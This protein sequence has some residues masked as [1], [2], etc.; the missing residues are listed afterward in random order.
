MCKLKN[1]LPLNTLVTLYNTLILPY[2]GFE[3]TKVDENCKRDKISFSL[4]KGLKFT[5]I[6]SFHPSLKDIFSLR[7]KLRSHMTA[8]G[9]VMWQ[10]C[11][12]NQG[13]VHATVSIQRRIA[14]LDLNSLLQF[15]LC[16]IIFS[17]KYS[18]VVM[19]PL[20]LAIKLVMSLREGWK[21]LVWVNFRR[22]WK[23]KLSL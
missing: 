17:V 4:H 23:E 5:H 1:Y 21:L 16:G 18:W 2:L 12:I 8:L 10:E 22:L 15:S 7:A 19:W 14:F 13:K 11:S 3:L 9:Q 20:S 6:K